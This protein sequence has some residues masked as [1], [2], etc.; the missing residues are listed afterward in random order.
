MRRLLILFIL[1]YASLNLVILILT[2]FGVHLGAVYTSLTTTVGFISALLLVGQRLSWRQAWLLLGL[3][4]SISLAME[5]LG[6]A[7][8]LVYGPYHYTERLGPK[9][10]GLVPYLVALAWFMMMAPAYQI[11]SRLVELR[12]N[13]SSWVKILV[14]AAIGG[15]IMTAW[16]VALDPLMVAAGHW[17]WDPPGEFFGVPLQNYWGWWLT[18]FLVFALFGLLSYRWFGGDP[19]NRTSAEQTKDGLFSDRM[20]VYSYCITGLSSVIVDLEIGLGGPALAGFF[21]LFPWIVISWV[22]IMD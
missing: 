12:V 9:F 5:S 16:D 1:V 13:W 11:A 15:V 8:G 14:T 21:A 10:L 17:V 3:S 7:T 22:V 2:P 6:V 20:A 18:T 19:V 4:F